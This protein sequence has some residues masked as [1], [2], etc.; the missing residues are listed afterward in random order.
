[1]ARTFGAGRC[2]LLLGALALASAQQS[3]V[4]HADCNARSSLCLVGRP[5]QPIR[6]QE[7]RAS[8]VRA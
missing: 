1:M 8:A 3:C 7:C 4:E 6:V 2:L 5:Q